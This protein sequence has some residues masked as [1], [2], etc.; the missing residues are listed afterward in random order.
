MTKKK[1]LLIKIGDYSFVRQDEALLRK[2][3]NVAAFTF[4]KAKG[5]GNIFRQLTLLFWLLK[6]IKGAKY[7][8]CWFSDFHAFFPAFFSKLFGKP[9]YVI[10][11]G[12]DGANLP[13]Y[14]YGAHRKPFWSRIIRHNCNRAQAI[15]PLSRFLGEKLIGEVGEQIRDKVIPVHLGIPDADIFKKPPNLK[16]DNAVIC[17]TGGDSLTR[18]KIKGMDFYKEVAAAYPEVR[19]ILVGVK[20]EA[21]A[22]MEENKP[23]N[24]EVIAFIKHK[25]LVELYNQAKVVCLFSRYEGFGMVMLEGMLC[26]CVPVTIKGIG[27]AEI[28][29][30]GVGFA[31]EYHDVVLAK[32]A[33]EKALS[34]SDSLGPKARQIALE[35]F[36][37][38][39]RAGII[40]G[41]IEK[42]NE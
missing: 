35:E 31:I 14:N 36:S 11:G 38:E 6:S 30:A 2:H 18:V 8:L 5:I 10:V 24:L 26:E 28:I 4:G 19:F 37:M 21:K 23:E 42:D 41:E 39:K 1:L 27:T 29:E 22:F 16:K 3:F 25:G 12:Y 17:V 40:I 34:E 32:A 15:F 7:V 20:G 9:F 33:I 13:E